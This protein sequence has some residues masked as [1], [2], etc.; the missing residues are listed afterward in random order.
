MTTKHNNPTKLK[1]L[2]L[3]PLAN[4]LMLFFAIFV[5]FKNAWIAED[6]YINF[7]SVEQLFAGNGPVWNPHERVQ[8]YTSPLWYSI[9]ASTRFISAD[10]YN[11]TITVSFLFFL[12]LILITAKT[13]RNTQERFFILTLAAFS[14][15][16][17]DFT[18]SGLEN[19]LLYTLVAFLFYHCQKI[20]KQEFKN[21]NQTQKYL[22]RALVTTGLL[23]LT[24]HDMLTLIWP[25]IL[26]TIY[27][28]FKS[29]TTTS[30]A[31]QSI[32]AFSPLMIFT[33]F[34]VIYYGYPFP[35]TAY[36]KL[37]TGISSDALM[38]QGFLYIKNL[39]DNDPVTACT[40]SFAM[41][42][43]LASRNCFNIAF[44][45]GIITNTLYIIRVGGDFMQGRFFSTAFVLSALLAAKIIF[46]SEL[47]KKITNK[48]SLVTNCLDKSKK[49]AESLVTDIAIKSINTPAIWLATFI[50]LKNFTNPTLPITTDIEFRDNAINNG[51]ANERGYY[52]PYLSLHS[53]LTFIPTESNPIFPQMQWSKIG[54]NIK[55]SDENVFIATSG[56]IG[57]TG[58]IS[59]TKKIIIDPLALSDPLLA[60][61]PISGEWRIGHFRREV[62]EEYI[63]TLTGDLQK[64]SSSTENK[65]LEKITKIT[66]DKNLFAPDRLLAI[67]EENLSLIKTKK[68]T[69]NDY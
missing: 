22:E 52:F 8:V 67:L 44:S 43:G 11:N 6:A 18:T 23:I 29:R 50:T 32:K 46:D 35:N 38:N 24:R 62:P 63:K 45:I 37:N 28:I 21:Q 7:R 40:I 49:G 1:S 41:L 19:I 27:Y 33:I 25:T 39:I 3:I 20:S 65:Y 30:A 42:M 48:A 31:W 59:G 47:T 64:M 2:I 14:S 53:K 68:I 61:K 17:Y 60:R 9:I 15:A 69:K 26:L 4:W 34:S 13:Y 55:N 58:Y 12:I 54:L 66:R 5:F 36:A 56:N 51:I 16:F 10:L 57:V